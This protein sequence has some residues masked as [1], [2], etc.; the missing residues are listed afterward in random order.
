MLFSNLQLKG[1]H[2]L[3]IIWFTPHAIETIQTLPS[4]NFSVT[5]IRT[6][7]TSKSASTFQ[8]QFYLLAI[9]RKLAE[10]PILVCQYIS[11]ITIQST[12]A[13]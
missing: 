11:E 2:T 13:D 4:I 1:L 3:Q 8:D 7:H 10:S 9:K 12:S 6:H 5:L